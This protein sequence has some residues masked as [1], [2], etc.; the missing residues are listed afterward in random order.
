MNERDQ[1]LRKARLFKSEADWAD[2]R[3]LGNQSNNKLKFGKA[4]FYQNLLNKKVEI[5]ETFRKL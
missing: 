2:Y 3:R 1:V 5:H 4:N